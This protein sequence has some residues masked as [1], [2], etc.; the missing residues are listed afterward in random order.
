MPSKK[1][2]SISLR[3]QFISRTT[4]MLGREGEKAKLWEFLDREETFLWWGIVGEGGVGKSRLALE[5]ALEA[6]AKGWCAGFMGKG[7]TWEKNCQFLGRIPEDWPTKPILL[8]ADDIL[9]QPETVGELVENLAKRQENLKRKVRFLWLER[10]GGEERWHDRFLGRGFRKE[11]IVKSQHREDA[12]ELL[13]LPL[14]T[15]LDVVDQWPGKSVLGREAVREILDRLKVN[16]RPLYA[17][18]LADALQRGAKGAPSWSKEDLVKEVLQNE[19]NRWRMGGVNEET[20]IPLL[21]LATLCGGIDT[22]G[23]NLPAEVKDMLQS[24][25]GAPGRSWKER[26]L[27]L[28]GHAMTVEQSRFDPMKPDLLGELFLLEEMQPIVAAVELDP[29]LKECS[30]ILEIAWGYKPSEVSNFLSRAASDFPDQPAIWSLMALPSRSDGWVRHFWGQTVVNV[31]AHA[32]AHTEK[33]RKLLDQL[34]AIAKE[35]SAT[36]ALWWGYYAMGAFNLINVYGKEGLKEAEELYATLA[37]LATAHPCEPSLRELQAKGAVNLINVYGK[38]G[39]KEA[40]ELYA[41]LASLATA[42]PCEPSLRE[43]QAKGAFN[44]INMYGKEGLKEAEELYATL[45]S[46]A[47]AHPCEPSLRE[48]QATGAV[49]LIAAYGKEELKEAEELY[50]TLVSL[51]TAHS[52]EP[53]LRELQAKGAANLIHVYDKERLKEAEELYATLVSLATAHS[54][55]PSLWEA[56]AGGAVNLIHAYG[57]EELKAAVKLYATLAS[58]ATAHPGESSLREAQAE[59]AVNLIKAYGKEGLKD[60]VELYATLASLATAH[61]GEPSLRELQAKGAVNLIAECGKE[62]LKDAEE[63]YATLASLAT[64]HPGEPSLRESQ[65]MGAVNLIGAYGKEGLP[66]ALKLYATLKS[67]ADAHSVEPS[68]RE[69]Q[70]R[71]A[72]NL[73]IAYDKEGLKEAVKLYATLEFLAK[74]QPSLRKWQAQGAVNLIVFH[75][76]NGNLSQAKVWRDTLAKLA[77]D[78][79]DELTLWQL[80]EMGESRFTRAL[81]AR[82]WNTPYGYSW[83]Q[84]YGR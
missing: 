70:A 1:E 28:T 19:R 61:P 41:T 66:Q 47:T 83:T 22:T 31:L 43:L 15:M 11:K 2:S 63:L 75:G 74:L 30:R 27:C 23:G 20:D 40:E 49:N 69:W 55:E 10:E 7:N 53:S 33:A 68:L 39:L 76:Q 32:D 64:A 12:L 77:S 56:Q 60:A 48:S 84:G 73:I 78:H 26:S 25:I 29:K 34:A 50:A 58:L 59:G 62:G 4:K 67:L 65:A 81:A 9:D 71:G 36:H 45:A 82:S 8:L 46:L 54:C 42:H 35:P 57:K 24:A 79:P 17:L 6:E 13:S 37:S 5:I 18:F 16:G 52:G 51:A 38:E 3:F 44:L 80:L 72:V 14:D 21:I